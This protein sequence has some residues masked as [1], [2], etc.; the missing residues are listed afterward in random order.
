M[1]AVDIF[2]QLV[3]QRGKVL[4][5][6]Y[7][8]HSAYDDLIKA[9]LIEEAGVVSSIVCDNC[10]HP[11]ETKIEYQDAEYGFLCPDIGFQQVNRADI[12]SVRPKIGTFVAQ[13]AEDQG[14][15]RRKS[16]PLDGET[17]RLGAL[18]TPAG[19]VA[20]YFQ[21]VMLDAKDIAA[22]QRALTGEMKASFGIVLTST[23][24]LSVPFYIT[25]P[26]KE[27]LFFDPE[28][29]GFVVDLDLPS[30][31]G[32]PET[33]KGGRPSAYKDTL[34]KLIAQRARSYD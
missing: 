26:L 29:G 20:V 33:R 11:H 21:A 19:D 27:A 24:A 32:I 12:V 31:A 6:S 4:A 8:H 5:R 18:E 14:C 16:T 22:F 17:W 15:K 25:V 23:G 9:G 13:L 30:I 28:A 10:D 3:E 7:S 34:T 1:D 2:S